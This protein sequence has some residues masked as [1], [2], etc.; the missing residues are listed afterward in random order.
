M[1]HFD[2]KINLIISC[3]GFHRELYT[4]YSHKCADWRHP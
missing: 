4:V 1:Q 3:E 2:T